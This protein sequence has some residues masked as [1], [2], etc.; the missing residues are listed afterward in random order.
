MNVEIGTEATQFLF[1]EHINEIFAVVHPPYFIPNRARI[2]KCL[3]SEGIDSISLGIDFWAS[4]KGLQIQAQVPVWVYGWT[5]PG[6]V[7]LVVIG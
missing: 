5:K 1:W 6:S 2:D 7:L 4:F 3:R